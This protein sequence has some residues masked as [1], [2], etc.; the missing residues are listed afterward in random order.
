MGIASSSLMLLIGAIGCFG[1][2]SGSY[3]TWNISGLIP[4][5]PVEAIAYTFLGFVTLMLVI[6]IR[7][8]YAVWVEKFITLLLLIIGCM[9]W[10]TAVFFPELDI[11]NLVVAP[12]T[13]AG[14]S[15]STDIP[16]FSALAIFLGVIVLTRI[17]FMKVKWQYY[18]QVTGTVSIIIFATGFMSLIGYAFGTPQ[19]YGTSA[20]PVSLSSAFALVFFGLAIMALHGSSKYPLSVFLSDNISAQMVRILIPIIVAAFLV[21]SWT[22]F[23]VVI[24]SSTDP[25][26]S[27]AV[28]TAISIAAVAY[29][30]SYVSERIRRVVDKSQK[31]KEE[32]IGALSLANKKLDILDSITRHDILNQASLASIEAE[33][34]KRLSKEPLIKQSAENIENSNKKII[35]L[36]QFSKEYRKV[37]LEEPIWIDLKEL[38]D[39]ATEQFDLRKVAMDFYCEDWMIYADP[40]IVKVFFNILDNSLRHGERVTKILIN[41]I[42]STEDGTLRILISDN[43]IG[44]PEEEKEKI[45]EK[46]FGKNTGL[47]LFL[48]RQILLITGISISEIG[49]LGKGAR[50]EIIVPKECFK[51]EVQNEDL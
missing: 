51:E 29:T 4:I 25:V 17:T 31:E 42:I 43:G 19:F 32:A 45:F 39:S 18:N 9:F 28:F 24:P 50:F 23:R 37:G 3:E 49:V 1:W 27:I 22:I 2:V 8:A 15:V 14:G 5:S 36:L 48:V 13:G 11:Q 20:T 33:L 34:L 47:G 41:C 6:P 30:V 10:I 16:P 7:S 26:I 21:Y 46:G 38:I 40:M 35:S 12:Q 44:V